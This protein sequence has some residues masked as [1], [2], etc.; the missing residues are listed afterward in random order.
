MERQETLYESNQTREKTNTVI[1]ED[2][3]VTLRQLYYRLQRVGG[4]C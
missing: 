2:P 1:A 3:A 4:R